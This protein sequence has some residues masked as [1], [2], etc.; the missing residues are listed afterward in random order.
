LAGGAWNLEAVLL[1][2]CAQQCRSIWCRTAATGSPFCL[3]AGRRC[4]DHNGSWLRLRH[5]ECRLMQWLRRLLLRLGLL[6]RWRRGQLS[7]L[8]QVGQDCLGQ[9]CSCGRPIRILRW[10]LR[11]LLS[12]LWCRPTQQRLEQGSR[13]SAAQAA[14]LLLL[15]LLLGRR[16]DHRQLRSTNLRAI[17][18][19]RMLHLL[20]QPLHA[21]HQLW[22]Q[23]YKRLRP[24]VL[25]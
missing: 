1:Q 15:L 22:E 5:A 13:H 4:S 19:P 25:Q 8:L 23:R 2:Q 17:L 12:L 11:C 7:L 6:R 18:L 21:V 20:T 16:G 24:W 14:R 9:V 3:R 10:R